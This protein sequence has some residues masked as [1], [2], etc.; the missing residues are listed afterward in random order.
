[1]TNRILQP[2]HRSLAVLCGLVF[3]LP[4]ILH[5]V[6]PS[7]N[8]GWGRFRGERN[9]GSILHC[10]VPLPWRSS[11][12]AWEAALPGQ[13]NAS[14]I[15]WGDLAFVSS[16]DLDSG[17]QHLQAIQV[18]SGQVQWHKTYPSRTYP[19]HARSS[20]ASSTPCANESAVFFSWANPDN[21]SLIALRHDGSEL[22]RRDQLG[23]YVSQHGFGS[24]PI[25]FGQT[26]ILF[27]SQD[28]EE[29]PAGVAPGHSRVMAFD[30]LTGNLLWETPRATTRVCYSTPTSFTDSVAGPA[31]LLSNAGDGLSAL[32]LETGKVLWEQK[33][34]SKRCISS[35]LVVGNMAIGTEGSGGGGNELFAVNLTEPHQLL[36]KIN[37]SAPYVPTPVALGDLLFLWGDTGIV[38]CLKLPT[39]DVVWSKRIGGNV[40]SSPVIAGD[41]LIGIAEDGTVSIL[42]AASEFS[43]LGSIKL[44]ETC[45]AT[46]ALSEH[47][48]L[49]RTQSRLICVGSPA[50]LNK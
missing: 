46:P 3:Y 32:S 11:D 36:F 4:L 42:A 18:S 49:L 47:F 10:D 1:M 35:P 25:L 20:F 7:R 44:E 38:S 39:G 22:W 17:E 6:E 48:I 24:S 23:S 34:F 13:G 14:P 40:S 31:L 8:I 16:A 29:L 28:A 50:H 30:S 33:V 12:V 45:R 26:L 2:M 21:L 15:L 41:K 37:R 5:A 43:E 9:T 19:V 27:N